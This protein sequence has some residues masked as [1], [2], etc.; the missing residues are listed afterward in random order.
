[1]M[2]SMLSPASPIPWPASLAK[3]APAA[4]PS[5]PS[6]TY[7]P[8]NHPADQRSA[9]TCPVQLAPPLGGPPSPPPSLPVVQPTSWRRPTPRHQGQPVARWK[10]CVVLLD[11]LRAI[12]GA[13][14]V[15]RWN[16]CVEL[17]EVPLW[18]ACPTLDMLSTNRRVSAATCLITP[19]YCPG[20]SSMLDSE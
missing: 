9:A 18:C 3:P 6:P 17:M 8:S 1:M 4:R 5:P 19:L 2:V 12:G 16:R 7:A 13:A 11:P 14:V 10:T 15:N 20:L